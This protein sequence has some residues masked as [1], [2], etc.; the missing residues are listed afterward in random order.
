MNEANILS[1]GDRVK[2]ADR[3]LYG[4]VIR[5]HFDSGEI[6]VMYDRNGAEHRH[7]PQNIEKVEA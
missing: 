4:K 7:Q 6:V 3:D 1:V 5:I 2:V